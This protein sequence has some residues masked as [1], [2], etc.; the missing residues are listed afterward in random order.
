MIFL[1]MGLYLVVNTKDIKLAPF[2]EQTLCLRG[3]KNWGRL[4]FKAFEGGFERI[5]HTKTPKC[6][7]F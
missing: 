3:L 6:M 4:F 5:I 7:T 2:V 1:V